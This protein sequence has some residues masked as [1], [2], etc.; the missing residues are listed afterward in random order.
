MQTITADQF[1]HGPIVPDGF[2]HL[3]Y[4]EA[5]VD[6]YGWMSAFNDRFVVLQV[7]G[8]HIVVEHD[9]LIFIY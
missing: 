9:T 3:L 4:E 5:E 2:A 1:C 7:D 6:V 8:G